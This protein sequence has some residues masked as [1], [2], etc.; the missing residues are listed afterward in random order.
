LKDLDY[1]ISVSEKDYKILMELSKELQL[2]END[3]QA[4]PYFWGAGSPFWQFCL[5]ELLY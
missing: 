3:N 4:C 1:K 5:S 2:Q